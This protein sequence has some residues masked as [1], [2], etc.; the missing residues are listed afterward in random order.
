MNIMGSSPLF[1]GLDQSEPIW[2][3][4]GDM[5]TKLPVGFATIGSTS[6]CTFTAV[7]N[8]QRN[9]YG[10][11][12]HPEVAHTARGEEIIENFVFGI[13]GCAGEWTPGSPGMRCYLPPS[14]RSAPRF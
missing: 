4:H 1:D 10:L 7:S 14:R 9:Y 8:E 13:A 3:S 6:D 5:V 11:Q 12:F 2:M